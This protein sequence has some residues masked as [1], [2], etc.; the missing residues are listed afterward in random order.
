MSCLFRSLASFIN[1]V[2][3]VDL[4]KMITDYLQ[5][6][7]IIVSPDQKLS[8]ILKVDNI[9]LNDYVELMR[10]E[11]TWGS[12]IEIKA[13][14]DMFQSK[15]IVHLQSSGKTIEFYPNNNI[16]RCEFIIHWDGGHYEPVHRNE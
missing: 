1:N 10:K 4:R 11:Y 2:S 16:I 8:D 14:C 12:A 6:D 5:T 7:P 13:F 15:V 3:E 9:Q